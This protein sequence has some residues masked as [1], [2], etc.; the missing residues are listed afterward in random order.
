MAPTGPTAMPR[1]SVNKPAPVPSPPN[2]NTTLGYWFVTEPTAPLSICARS[3]TEKTTAARATPA[4][5]IATIRPIETARHP[6]GRMGRVSTIIGELAVANG[7]PRA[8]A[9][10]STTLGLP[11]LIV[12]TVT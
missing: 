2:V 10:I 6:P 9:F 1:G 7:D 4:I 8:A 3:G 5:G 12:L 11:V